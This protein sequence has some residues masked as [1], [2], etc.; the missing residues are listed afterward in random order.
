MSRIAKEVEAKIDFEAYPPMEQDVA[1]ALSEARQR[2]QLRPSAEAHR[3]PHHHGPHRALRRS[4]APEGSGHRHDDRPACLSLPESFLGPQSAPH[5]RGSSTR[6]KVWSTSRKK[7]SASETSSTR[8][9]TSSSLAECQQVCR[10]VRTSSRF[11]RS[12]RSSRN[13]SGPRFLEGGTA[14][15]RHDLPC[16]DKLQH[17]HDREKS[18]DPRSGGHCGCWKTPGDRGSHRPMNEGRQRLP[19]CAHRVGKN[20]RDKNPKHRSLAERVNGPGKTANQHEDLR[21]HPE[22]VAGWRKSQRASPARE[23]IRMSPR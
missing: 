15:L 18:K 6:L 23:C 9:T 8:V 11:T 20:L 3:R 13:S 14:R 1:R 12:P 4:A 10:T 21:V 19:L 17:H 2:D 16:E 7:L 22:V 5:I